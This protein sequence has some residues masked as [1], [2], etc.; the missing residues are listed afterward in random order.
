M[1][2]TVDAE[3]LINRFQVDLPI[4]TGAGHMVMTD[5]G[6]ILYSYLDGSTGANAKW[7]LGSFDDARDYVTWGSVTNWA[8]DADNMGNQPR[9]VKADDG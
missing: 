1:I 4:G 7:L 5:K 8:S 6:Q 9:I 3:R 2:Y